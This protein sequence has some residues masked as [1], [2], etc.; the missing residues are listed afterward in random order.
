MTRAL[1]SPTRLL[2]DITV[3]IGGLAELGRKAVQLE[4]ILDGRIGPNRSWRWARSE[5]GD[6]KTIKNTFG[7]TVNDV[8][9]AVITGAFRTFL[10][11][12]GEDVDGRSI[13][14]MVPV[15]LRRPG[16]P[17]TLGNQLS[18]LFADLPVGIADPVQRL[19]AVTGQLAG[20]KSHGMVA[21]M[22]RS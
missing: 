18:A 15:S 12:R 9:L 1:A 22:R 10:L 8:V 21:G 20:L 7:G 11:A 2:R 4:T 17:P 14:T 16:Q 3:D 13:R 19:R 5:L 6:V